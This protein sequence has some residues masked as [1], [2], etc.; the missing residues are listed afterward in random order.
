MTEGLYFG[1][2][3]EGIINMSLFRYF[4][5]LIF[6]SAGTAAWSQSFPPGYL[7]KI[8]SKLPH[9]F[10]EIRTGS[11]MEVIRTQEIVKIYALI[12]DIEQY[13]QVLIERSDE[14]G[15]NY[16]QCKLIKVEK[17]KYTNNY[18]EMT[19][20]YPVSS[21]MSNLYRVK[22]ITSDGIIRTYAPVPITMAETI[23]IVQK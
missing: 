13:E 1:T 2:H 21:K 10:K 11:T 23:G 12:D 8:N 4:I 14:L 9:K 19:D 20:R 16:G 7:E 3:F 6:I 18:I 22:T 5:L 15:T 17:G